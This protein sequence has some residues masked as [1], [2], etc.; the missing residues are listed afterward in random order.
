MLQKEFETRTGLQVTPAEYANIERMY[1]AC[2]NMNKDEFCK[3]WLENHKKPNGLIQ[4]L[5]ERMLALES[6]IKSL[7]KTNEG[8][9]FEI[10]DGKKAHQ[11]FV[12]EMADFLLDQSYESDDDILRAKAIELMGEK[13]YIIRKM[14]RSYEIS[15]KDR[16][17]LVSLLTESK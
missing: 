9:L 10:E 3:L 14:N 16:D 5:F 1:M 13:D 4:G 15:S 6:D 8:M 7:K 17:L 12:S 11:Q 2:E